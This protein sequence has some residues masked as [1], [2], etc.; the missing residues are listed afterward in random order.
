MMIEEIFEVLDHVL[1]TDMIFEQLVCLIFRVTSYCLEFVDTVVR[2]RY[3]EGLKVFIGFWCLDFIN[4][5]CI[6]G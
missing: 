4:E 2:G 5:Q 6:L 1:M 3:R